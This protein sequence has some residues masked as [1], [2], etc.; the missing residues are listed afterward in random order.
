MA[1]PKPD[2]PAQVDL[3]AALAASI[4]RAKRAR[5]E[6]AERETAEGDASDG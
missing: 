1:E 4:D 2:T 3:L 5:H 6:D